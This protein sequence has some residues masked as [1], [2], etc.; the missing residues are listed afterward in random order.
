MNQKHAREARIVNRVLGSMTKR[1]HALEVVTEVLPADFNEADVVRRTT[2]RIYFRKIV[3][4]TV[5]GHDVETE[6]I[7]SIPRVLHVSRPQDVPGAT[8]VKLS[9]S[10]KNAHE[11]RS[12]RKRKPITRRWRGVAADAITTRGE[13]LNSDRAK[14]VKAASDVIDARQAFRRLSRSKRNMVRRI[15]NRA[16]NGQVA[17]EMLPPELF[18]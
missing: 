7:D 8:P 13:V 3:V 12:H 10:V 16:N 14:A 15:A 11:S 9:R 18:R 4:S 1:D 2:K 17:T 5:D 6:V